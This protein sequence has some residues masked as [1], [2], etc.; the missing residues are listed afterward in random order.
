MYLKLS[1]ILT[2][3][4]AVTISL[5][6]GIVWIASFYILL[7]YGERY[8]TPNKAGFF[9]DIIIFF[10]SGLIAC[11]IFVVLMKIIAHTVSLL[12]KK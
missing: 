8:L 12:F 9:F 4:K 10:L 2:F 1:H 7:Q 3:I 6:F 11:F 5:V